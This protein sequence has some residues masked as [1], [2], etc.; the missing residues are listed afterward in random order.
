MGCFGKCG[1]PCC[2]DAQDMPFTSVSLI[3]PTDNC[4][5]GLG[6][7]GGDIGGVGIGGGGVGQQYP[8]ASFS[9]ANCCFVADFNLG[10]QEYVKNCAVLA[11]VDMDYGLNVDYYRSK[12]SYIQPG[13]T[14]DCPCIKVQ[15]SR[16]DSHVRHKAWWLER[17]KLIGIQIHVGKINVICTDGEQAC[18]F[19][20]AATYAFE[21]CE[22]ILGWGIGASFYPEYT[23][24]H[25]CTGV[26]RNGTCSYSGTSQSASSVNN[27]NDLKAGFPDQ[28]CTAGQRR[29]FSRI[30]LY[31]TLPTGQISITN[32][33]LPPVNC[34]NGSTGCTVTGSPCGLNLDSNCMP[35][36]PQFSDSLS[37][38]CQGY[39]NGP[40]EP[41]YPD[42]C[43][44][45]SGCPEV[46]TKTAEPDGVCEYFVF[47]SASGCYEQKQSI[48]TAPKPGRDRLVCGYCESGTG[49]DYYEY[50]FEEICN[51]GNFLCLT[52]QCCLSL[53][54]RNIQFACKEFSDPDSSFCRVD[55]SNYSCSIGSVQHYTAGAFCYALPTV[56]IQLS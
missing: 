16:I 21:T 28:Y 2:L 35:N 37:L 31:D 45:L 30:K 24:D 10:C 25:T 44:I 53:E 29:Y 42:G 36:L 23:V 34:C 54:D 14:P 50:P 6:G 46:L 55:I 12:A 47:D 1:C 48:N 27:C 33:D 22:F 51:A 17:H 3:A 5:G 13:G 43:S 19:Y 40:G 8:S 56:T 15:S 38:G 9:Q 32:A 20:V 4:E 49:R 41:P 39:T 7:G 11:T 18:K 26:Y 52:G